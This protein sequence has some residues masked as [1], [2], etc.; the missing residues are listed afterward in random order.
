MNTLIPVKAIRA[1]CLSCC[2]DSYSEIKNCI[3]PDCPLYQL[4]LGKGIK[5]KRLSSLRAIRKYCYG[6]GEGTAFDIKNCEISDCSLFVYR[7]GKNPNLKGKRGRGNPDALRN[8]RLIQ[9]NSQ[10]QGIV[11][12]DA[13]QKLQF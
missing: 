3:I 6:C 4:R 12:A 2:V 8:Y 9:R 10:K 13:N 1:K 5:G 7:F 11:E